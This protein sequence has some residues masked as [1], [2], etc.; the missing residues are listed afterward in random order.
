MRAVCTR[1]E[2]ETECGTSEEE[3]EEAGCPVD[4][5]FPDK[6]E[7]PAQIAPVYKGCVGREDTGR[8]AWV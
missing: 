2:G 1:R 5:E 8:G 6:G 7:S 3:Q 4:V